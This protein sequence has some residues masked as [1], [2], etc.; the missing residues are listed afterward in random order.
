MFQYQDS[1]TQLIWCIVHCIDD[2]ALPRNPNYLNWSFQ[3]PIAA[4]DSAVAT[5][6]AAEKPEMAPLNNASP[7]SASAPIFRV[8][9]EPRRVA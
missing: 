4:M 5:K 7:N 1:T 3:S 8:F 6:S 9:L 2:I